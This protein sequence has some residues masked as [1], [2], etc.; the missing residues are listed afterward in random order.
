[1]EI[2][3]FL[4]HI[5]LQ[6][7]CLHRNCLHYVLRAKNKHVTVFVDLTSAVGVAQLAEVIYWTYSK[8]FGWL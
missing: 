2:K 5:I 6:N 7:I 3:L 8:C 4:N 1:M